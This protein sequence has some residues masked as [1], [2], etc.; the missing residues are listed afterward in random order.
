MA[1]WTT[2]TIDIQNIE[3]AGKSGNLVIKLMICCNDLSLANQS[4]ARWKDT[5][6]LNI[7][8]KS[9]QQG[10]GMYFV[11]I[12]LSHLYEGLNIIKQIADEP[13]LVALIQGLDDDTKSSFNTLCEYLD[14]APERKKLTRYIELMR[15]KLTFHYDES[16][17]LIDKAIGSLASKKEERIS[18]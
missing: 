4:L 12:Q 7:D 11:R 3:S 14:G 15:H 5:E 2:R 8:E 18:R 9:R 10:A 16:P 6:K 1:K 17:K 13:I